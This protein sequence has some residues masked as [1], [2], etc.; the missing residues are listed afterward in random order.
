MSKSIPH[1]LQPFIPLVEFLGSV[2]GSHCEIVLHDVSN[3]ENSIVAISNSH[4][5]NRKVGGS[6]TDLALK[7]LKNKSNLEKDFLIN[8]SGK[9]QDGKIVRSSTFFIKDDIGD[10]VGM[11]CVNMDVSQLVNTRNLIDTLINGSQDLPSNGLYLNGKSLEESE[12]PI[13]DFH[14]S[15]EDLTTSIILQTLSEAKI[16][17]DRM[18]PDEKMEIVKQL[19][20]KGVFL[21]KGAVA[22][23]AVHMCTSEATIYRY[24]NKIDTK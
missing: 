4:I 23:V 18:S 9:T 11:L 2:M 5:S 7:V 15:I 1:Q 3:V 10:V 21:I 6:L 19:N 16:S 12:K 8:Y 20:E 17:P 24:L 22:E 13:E 14:T